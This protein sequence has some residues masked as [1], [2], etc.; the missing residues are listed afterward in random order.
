MERITRGKE[1]LNAA[2]KMIWEQPIQPQYEGRSL[3][4]Y[5]EVGMKHRMSEIRGA[6]A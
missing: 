2:K 4:F 3:S 6:I 5:E 1:F